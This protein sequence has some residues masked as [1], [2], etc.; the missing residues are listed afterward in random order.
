MNNSPTNFSIR[1]KCIL[2]T[3]NSIDCIYTINP[4]INSVHHTRR[5][6]A[7]STILHTHIK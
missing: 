2:L 7:G 6:P 3:L 1:L 5:R 4:D